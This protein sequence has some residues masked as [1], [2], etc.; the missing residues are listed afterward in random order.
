MTG[1]VRPSPSGLIRSTLLLSLFIA[2]DPYGTFN[3]TPDDALGPVDPVLF[4]PAN[5]GTG[6]DRKRPGRGRF[7]ELTAFVNAMPV[8]YVLY[9][10]PAVPMGADPLR[11]REAGK[12]YGP[13]PTP[14]AYVFDATA[15]SPFPANEVYP[16]TP[17]AGYT[18]DQRRDEVD[19]TKQNPVFT[20]LPRPPTRRA[21]RRPRATCRWSRRRG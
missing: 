2:C 12:P 19:Y 7:S 21:R 15:D 13:V 9:A 4:P 8:G 5:I 3:D 6:G 14:T 20:D 1:S 11:V 18:F 17:P 16:C 10:A